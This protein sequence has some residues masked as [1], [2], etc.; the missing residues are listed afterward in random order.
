MIR[1]PTGLEMDQISNQN[2]DKAD[3]KSL[4]KT[5]YLTRKRRCRQDSK[6]VTNGLSYVANRKKK[7]TSTFI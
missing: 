3:L 1:I 7:I 5:N 2:F 4:E 6:N